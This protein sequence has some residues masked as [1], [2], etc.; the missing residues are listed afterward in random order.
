[1]SQ[2]FVDN[3]RNRTGGAIGAPSGIIVTGVSTLSG[4]VSIGGTLTYE[5]VTNIDSVGII[6]AQSGI[7]V[8]AGGIDAVGVVT[9]TSLESSGI[10][11]TGIVTATSLESSGINVT[12]IVTATSIDS[13][14][15]NITGVIT[16]T[17]FS[18]DGSNLSGVESGVANFVAS[19][20]I[21]NGAPVVVNTDGTVGIV[22][23][24][25]SAPPSGGTPVVFEA[26]S[27]DWI[28]TVYD[29]INQRVV[30]AY[31]DVDN[32][33]HGTAIV[34]TVSG[35]VITFGTPVVFETNTTN[36]TSAAYDSANQK[37]VIAYTD[38]SNHGAAIV[39]TV[40]GD[41]ITFGTKTKFESATT[42]YPSIR[43]DSTN[44]KVV[45]AYRDSGNRGDAIVGTVSGTS[46]TF[47]TAVQFDA[48]I[49]NAFSITYDSANQ[50]VVIAYR[51]A[52]PFYGKAIVGTVSGTSIT[53]GTAVTFESVNIN[54]IAYQ[55]G[56]VYDSTNAKVI[57]TYRINAS[58]YSGRAIV[59]TVSGTSITFGTSAVF[60]TTQVTHM[61]ATYDTFNQKVIIGYN[62]AS[63]TEGYGVVGTVSGTSITFGTPVELGE[64]DG[65][66]RT[67]AT[68]D[69]LN[70]K[71][72][73]AYYDTGNSSHGTAVVFGA[74]T[75]TLN[76]TADNYIG[77][78]AEAIS[79]TATGKVNI[80]GGINTGQ[81]GLTTALKYYVQGDGTLRTI[82]Y[83]SGNPSVVAGTA[84]SDTKILVR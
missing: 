56:I 19:G 44:E 58:P 79:D 82:P 32:S 21:P 76:L 57:I 55:N 50:K 65:I 43:Y 74:T 68:F 40:S 39:G 37:V 80:L 78:A 81:T 72:I 60:N 77:F 8:N 46:I 52:S 62:D 12:G 16:A 2:L 26:A 24:T 35:T 31:K 18:G 11:V 63:G 70:N 14:G 71:A 1:M 15:I 47:G 22:T 25:S 38:S 10:N 30:I 66:T 17:S 7:K 4:N 83:S 6:T 23:L 61:A 13:S 41:T 9:A 45:I 73:F 49:S 54:T 84:I 27:T 51:D 53:F 3:I 5:D 48:S 69:S 67:A 20:T 34:G 75:D 29:P 36:Y 64:P 33:N 42:S 28:S 59:G